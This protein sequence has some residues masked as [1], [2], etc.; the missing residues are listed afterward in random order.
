MK[1][2]RMARED[3]CFDAALGADERDLVSGFGGNLRQYQG[4]HE[5]PSSTSARNQDLHEIELRNAECGMRNFSAGV[6]AGSRDS[7]PTFTFR[8]PQ[9]AI[10]TMLSTRVQRL[11]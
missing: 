6:D 11:Q 4:R 9:F 1:S 3:L 10:R 8:T 7:N 2:E 5:G